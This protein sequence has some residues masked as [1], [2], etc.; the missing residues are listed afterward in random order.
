[1]LELTLRAAYVGKPVVIE[2]VFGYASPE[3]ETFLARS[4]GSASGWF[5]HYG[6]VSPRELRGRRTMHDALWAEWLERYSRFVR[7]EVPSN[8][9]ARAP[10]S[11]FADVPIIS[12]RARPDV[13]TRLVE[14]S[15]A[16][17][18]KGEYLDARLA[19]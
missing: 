4:L 2:E 16:Q 1:M 7:S 12:L 3:L 11:A 6:G 5:S 9:V 19:P 15:R 17:R 13:R 8:G 18:L 10:G 14:L